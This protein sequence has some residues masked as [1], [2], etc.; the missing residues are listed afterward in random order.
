MK[1]SKINKIKGKENKSSYVLFLYRISLALMLMISLLAITGVKSAA[2]SESKNSTADYFK[3]M[4][5]KTVRIRN[6][7]LNGYSPVEWYVIGSDS[8]TVTLL[9]KSI[10]G[11]SIY[12]D[13]DVNVLY[14]N[15]DLKAYV[16]SLIEDGKA[17]AML[18][19][20]LAEA[21]GFGKVPYIL[22][23]NAVKTLSETKRRGDGNSW[24]LRDKEKLSNHASILY[25]YKY[26]DVYHSQMESYDNTVRGQNIWDSCGV[27]PVIKLDLNK[28]NYN[29]RSRV[30][31]LKHTHKWDLETDSKNS[32]IALVKCLVKDC[33]YGQNE[34]YKFRLTVADK[35]YDGSVVEADLHKYPGFHKEIFLSD[36]Y[37]E[38]RNGTVYKKNILPPTAKGEYTAFIDLSSG[39]GTSDNNKITLSDDFTI[40]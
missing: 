9:S 39:E 8:E 16:E 26:T 21:S 1:E 30:F 18:K 2:A 11:T 33:P 4:G 20:L 15:S 37:Y 22:N 5:D 27:R 38:G 34:E 10:F 6:L 3:D 25:L 14:N 17:L 23:E 35:N 40:K 36:V 12:T 28:I 32:N 7:S 13:H 29:P 24:W 19:D 31:Y